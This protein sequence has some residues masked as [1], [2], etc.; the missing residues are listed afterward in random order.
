MDEVA[1]RAVCAVLALDPA[2]RVLLVRR[3]DDGTWGLPGGGV[4]PGETWQL[5]AER[6]CREETG[7][8]VAVTGLYGV[9]SDPSTQMHCYRDGRRCGAHPPPCGC[10]DEVQRFHTAGGERYPVLHAGPWVAAEVLCD[11]AEDLSL[12]AQFPPAELH[13]PSRGQQRL[14]GREKAFDSIAGGLV[15]TGPDVHLLRQE[16]RTKLGESVRATGP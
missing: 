3:A 1:V 9:Y 10:P 5:A 15:V 14:L 13:K 7:W 6:E 2:Q 16:H 12:A 8:A 4:E 11:V